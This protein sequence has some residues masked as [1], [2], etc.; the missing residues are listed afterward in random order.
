MTLLSDQAGL[1]VAPAFGEAAGEQIV[2]VLMVCVLGGGQLGNKQERKD[3]KT[4]TY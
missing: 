2:M 4:T 1:V 3:Q